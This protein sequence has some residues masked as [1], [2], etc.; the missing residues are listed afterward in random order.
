MRA[1]LEAHYLVSGGQYKGIKKH[2][3][4]VIASISMAMTEARRRYG[5]KYASGIN[6]ANGS[7][8]SLLKETRVRLVIL[9]NLLQG[10][11]NR[12]RI[13]CSK[14]YRYENNIPRFWITYIIQY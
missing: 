10:S 3:G 5:V 14:S 1:Q 8:S 4:E 11:A 2:V 13:Y 7:G 12:V 6:T 9:R